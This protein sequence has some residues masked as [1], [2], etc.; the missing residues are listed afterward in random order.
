MRFREIRGQIAQHLR[1]ARHGECG[2]SRKLPI[3]FR[4]GFP[5][6]S[7][8][9]QRGQQRDQAAG[10]QQIQLDTEKDDPHEKRENEAGLDD[11]PDDAVGSFL[12]GAGHEIE[13]EIIDDAAD[14]EDAESDE[15]SE[16]RDLRESLI[17]PDGAAHGQRQQG[18]ADQQIWNLDILP[19]GFSHDVS[20][21]GPAEPH[22]NHRTDTEDN[23]L[24]NPFKL[25]ETGGKL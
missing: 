10:P 13:L 3:A 21:Q 22:Q 1:N 6:G 18:T 23:H 24:K 14:H 7:E 16:R 15:I 5:A 11:A 12:H 9:R 2:E 20:E 19:R 17:Q 4:R 25:L 8:E